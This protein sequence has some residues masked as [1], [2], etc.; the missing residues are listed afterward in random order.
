MNFGKIVT[1]VALAVAV[2]AML[3]SRVFAQIQTASQ[4]AVG[5]GSPVVG[6]LTPEGREKLKGELEGRLEAFKKSNPEKGKLE[7]AGANFARV[8]EAAGRS[9]GDG[10]HKGSAPGEHGTDW[11]RIAL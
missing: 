5:T 8:L 1:L 2:L 7:K 6:N 9:G 10:E 4:Q 11:H 3:G